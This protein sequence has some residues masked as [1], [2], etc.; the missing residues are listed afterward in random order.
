MSRESESRAQRFDLGYIM[1]L[2]LI[3]AVSCWLLAM[4]F[5]RFIQDS[6]LHRFHLTTRHFAIW[7]VQQ[8][9]PAMYNFYN[10]FEVSPSPWKKSDPSSVHAETLNHFPLRIITFGDNRRLFLPADEPRQIDIWSRYRGNELRTRY[11]A[12]PLPDGGFQ[13]ELEPIP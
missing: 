2:G 10:R 7:A 9:I 1:I 6:T 5:S 12:T 4:P 3:V 8:P 13:L 11:L